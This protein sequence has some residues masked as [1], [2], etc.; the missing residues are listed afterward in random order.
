MATLQTMPGESCSGERER[1]GRPP[2]AQEQ[3]FVRARGS[4]QESEVKKRL[5]FLLLLHRSLCYGSTGTHT[6]LDRLEEEEEATKA[7]IPNGRTERDSLSLSL[8]VL[9]PLKKLV[10]QAS[11]LA[12]HQEIETHFT[13]L[14]ENNRNSNNSRRRTQTD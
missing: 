4:S 5:V 3:N 12:A 1:A 2:L 14:S 13:R 11:K 8:S 6:F 7:T 10:V 9:L